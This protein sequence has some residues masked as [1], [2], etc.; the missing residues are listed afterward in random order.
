MRRCVSFQLSALM[1]VLSL[2]LGGCGQDQQ[3]TAGNSDIRLPEPE[4]GNV[5]TIIGEKHET[6]EYEVT[7]H[8]VSQNALSLSTVNRTIQLGQNENIIERTLE[9]L[10]D[11]AALSG[12]VGAE[13]E[14]VEF[15]CGIATVNLNL[16]SGVNRSEADYLSLCASI[17]NTLLQFEDVEAVNILTGNRSDPCSN[18]PIGAFVDA[19]D[20]IAA[21]Y[22][23]IQSEAERFPSDGGGSL[24]RNVL[25]YFPA[26]DGRY[27]L[28]EVRELNFEDS[29]YASELLRALSDGP[30]MRACSDA[31]LP[32]NS[33]FT[34]GTPQETIT[35]SG[36]RIIELR[37]SSAL[38][39]YLEFAG[40]EEWQLYSSV[41]LTLCSFMPELDAVRFY[42]DDEIVN[43]CDLN[44]RTL[45]FKDGL[46]RRNDFV[47]T[48]GSSACF[49]FASG[50]TKLTRSEFPVARHVSTS[51]LNL[52]R[53]LVSAQPL[54]DSDA[55]SVSP[56]GIS[57]SDILGVAVNERTATVNLSANFYAQC[58]SINPQEE[59]QLIYA[60]VN[61]L[62]EISGIDA[63]AFCVEG[64]T[65]SSL[66]HDIYLGVALMPDSGLVEPT[67]VQMEI[68]D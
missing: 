26:Q 14:Q 24:S 13:I 22:A 40:M 44:G 45:L 53:E 47:S 49:Y 11:S 25:L 41:V 62:T 37:F 36:E 50:N 39:D 4:T 5:Q 42:M 23:Q 64:E 55:R 56:E 48:I 65:V 58:Q 60:M 28:P 1:L 34:E 2:C 16:E 66:A 18:L 51:P 29:D 68:E 35:S 54:P 8:Y 27:V 12:A 63:V 9:A 21:L 19:Q 61:T 31:I 59:R 6:S 15:A 10:I 17:A 20:N 38:I 30:L 33:G 57:Q 67:D 32:G 7:L 52:L 3:S 43:H 46:M